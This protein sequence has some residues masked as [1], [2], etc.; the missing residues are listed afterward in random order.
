[1]RYQS[2]RGG[3]TANFSD[4]LLEGLAADGG[5][6]VPEKYPVV[7]PA[8]LASWRVLLAEQGY[9]ALAHQ[10]L[11]LF[12]TDIPDAELAR[13][14][15]SA[16]H[17]QVFASRVVTPVTPV[18]DTGIWLAHL[19]NGP[20]AAF[21]DIALQMLGRLFDY[22]L[23]RRDTWLTVLG[24]TSGDTGSSAEYA[25]RGLARV[26]VAMLTPHARMTPFQQA[27]MYSI[28]DPRIVNFAV[29]GVFDD[30]QDLVKALNSDAEFKATYHIGA[31]NSI[32]VA[33]LLAQ[34]VYAF[35]TWL[36]VAE[37]DTQRISFAVPTGNFGDILSVHVAHQMG[38]PV[39]ALILAT[40]ENNVLQEFFATG[41]YRPRPA[42]AVHATSSPSMDISKASNLERFIWD[43]VDGDSQ[44]SAQLF[45]HSD[46]GSFGVT[47]GFDLSH[48]EIFVT[49]RERFGIVAGASSHTDRLATIARMWREHG[50]LIDPHTAAGVHVAAQLLAKGEVRTPIIAYETALPVKFANTICEALGFEPPTVERFAGLLQKPQHAIAMAN[51]ANQVKSWLASW[52]T[53]HQSVP[54]H[55]H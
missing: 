7:T 45:T 55:T 14:T 52:L 48:D 5:L 42:H 47:G 26:K 36:Q 27:Q 3:S 39:D 54:P 29:A 28:D 1:M 8:L 38:L 49:Q 20:T 40:N 31:V 19:S 16:Y 33:R 25:M 37:S 53:D 22:E 13:L 18:G 51:D 46:D 30:C 2:T 17:E 41:V 32:N 21:K 34:V 24:A 6:Y 11:R 50:L 35:A 12:I 4:V 15:A 10:I 43:L 44:R 9:A 23:T